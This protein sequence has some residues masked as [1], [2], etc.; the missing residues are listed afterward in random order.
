MK[1]RSNIFGLFH[2]RETDNEVTKWIKSRIQV[3]GDQESK[4]KIVKKI[5]R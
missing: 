2:I 5:G 1:I 4:K 3:R